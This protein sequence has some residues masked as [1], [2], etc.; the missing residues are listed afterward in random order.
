MVYGHFL[1]TFNCRE[2]HG[3]YQG[4]QA[5]S[6]MWKV[7]NQLRTKCTSVCCDIKR[8]RRETRPQPVRCIV[9]RI[10]KPRPPQQIYRAYNQDCYYASVLLPEHF[11]LLSKYFLPITA[12]RLLS[13]SKTSN[14]GIPSTRYKA[15][16]DLLELEATSGQ[17]HRSQQIVPESSS[18]PNS[19][20]GKNNNSDEYTSIEPK[21]VGQ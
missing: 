14:T 18:E 3:P 1:P 9:Q 17:T 5:D 15:T 21:S 19:K 12:R 8:G 6:R 20:I 16:M 10:E 13:I 4:R 11:W 2:T 7:T